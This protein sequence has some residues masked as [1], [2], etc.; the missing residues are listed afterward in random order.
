MRREPGAESIIMSDHHDEHVGHVVPVRILFGVA[1]VLLFFTFITVVQAKAPAF[2]FGMANVYIALIIAVTKAS[3]VCLYFMH[4]RWDS[5]FN[6]MIL[7]SSV[8]FV[9]LM[10]GITITDTGE[11]KGDVRNWEKAIGRE[12]LPQRQ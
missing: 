7:L 9:G 11:Y 5:P 3:L 12:Q 10:I 8:V 4:L 6:L 1:M 2:D